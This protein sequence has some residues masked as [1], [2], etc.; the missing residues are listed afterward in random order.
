MK[1]ILQGF[2]SFELCGETVKQDRTQLFNLNNHIQNTN[3]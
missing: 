2:V 3:V 1:N